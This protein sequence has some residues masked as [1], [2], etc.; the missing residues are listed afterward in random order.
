VDEEELIVQ[1]HQPIATGRD[2]A[3]VH[4]PIVL[5]PL[6]STPSTDAHSPQSGSSALGGTFHVAQM[7]RAAG[8]VLLD[9]EGSGYTG[10]RAPEYAGKM[11]HLTVT[12]GPMHIGT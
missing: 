6:L 7:G 3:M 12:C 4:D 10:I 5:A 9:G 2:Q 11:F 1:L 8:F